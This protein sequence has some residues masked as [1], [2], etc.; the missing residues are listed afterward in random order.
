MNKHVLFLLKIF[1]KEKYAKDLLNGKIFANSLE[2]FV[3][4]EKGLDKRKDI[5]ED[6]NGW[7]QPV[8]SL[9]LKINDQ[10]IPKEDLAGPISIKIHRDYN[11]NL[12]CMY[13]CYVEDIEKIKKEN[14][15]TTKRDLFIEKD[16]LKLGDYAILIKNNTE[17]IERIKKAV[18]KNGLGLKANL[19]EYFD[20]KTFHGTF[21]QEESMF[22]KRE[23]Y[24]HQKEYRFAFLSNKISNNPINLEIGNIEDIAMLI[25]T[26][27]IDKLIQE[28]EI[29]IHN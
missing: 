2:Y 14:I 26:S 20:E 27:E 19:I 29:N 4:L 23:F 13:A 1:E 8:D 7:L 6:I 21:S 25:K 5:Y 15:E 11:I 9:I 28:A 18:K 12:F 17:F 10:T 22:R 3:K 16:L 24:K